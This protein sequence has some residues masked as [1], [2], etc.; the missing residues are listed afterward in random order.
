MQEV[1][2]TAQWNSTMGNVKQAVGGVIE[3]TSQ[4]LGGSAEPSSWTTAGEHTVIY[5]QTC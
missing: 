1:E 2:L 3:S 4:A 5:S